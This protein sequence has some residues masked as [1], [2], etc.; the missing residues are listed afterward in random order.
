MTKAPET[1]QVTTRAAVRQGME[2]MIELGVGSVLPQARGGVDYE[3]I[4]LVM[5][6]I[7]DL[8]PPPADLLALIP[9]L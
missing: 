6:E 5:V 8:P 9:G 4:A 1:T 7:P 3:G 2:T